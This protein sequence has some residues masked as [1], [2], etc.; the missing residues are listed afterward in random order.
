MRYY[1][2]LGLDVWIVINDNGLGHAGLYV[3]TNGKVIFDP[4]GNFR[5][6]QKG[7]GDMLNGDDAGLTDYVDFQRQDGEDV[8]VF[9]FPLTE[10]DDRQLIQNIE[11]IGAYVPFA[12]AACPSQA[13]R[14]WSVQEHH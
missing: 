8:G 1:D 7:S 3:N 4:G 13:A 10:K 2:S 14:R 12:R 6:Q 5:Q 11:D 9:H